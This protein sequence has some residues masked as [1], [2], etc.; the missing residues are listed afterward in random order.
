[1][2]ILNPV[3]IAGA[4]DGEG[5]MGIAP[6]VK[7]ATYNPFNPNGASGWDGV[8]DGILAM[9]PSGLQGANQYG[10]TS[11]INM[12]LGEAGWVVSQGLADLFARNDIQKVNK[13]TVYVIAAGNDGVTQT[14]D[15]E[16]YYGKDEATTIFVGSVNPRGEISSFSN[17]AGDTCLLDNGVCNEG[18]ELYLRTVVA[19]GELL[20]LSDG[21]GGVTRHSGTSFA[22]PLVSGAIALLH[23][24]WAWLAKEP[25]ATAK[26][27]KLLADWQATLPKGPSGNV[28]SN[29]RKK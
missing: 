2:N 29:L 18:N 24:R 9:Q 14:T 23:D 22:A 17:R 3:T 20:L 11:I 8:A 6:D 28:F 21:Q 1:M 10:V 15:I 7:I 25:E 16:W 26:L 13:D 19:P 5:V 12:S 4:H 27:K